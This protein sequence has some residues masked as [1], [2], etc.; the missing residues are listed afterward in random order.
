MPQPYDLI[1]FDWD[2]TIIDSTAV[3]SQ[4]LQA[5]CADLALPIPSDAVANH[6]IGLG[7]KDALDYAV[8]NLPPARIVELAERYRFHFLAGEHRA[9]LF[10]GVPDML[11]ALAADGFLLAV[12]TGKTRRGL[13]RSLEQTQ[14]GH[15][16]AAS[17]CADETFPKPHPAMLEEL[18]GL[19]NIDKSR[20]LM[21]GDTTHDLQMA[22]NAGCASVAV[23][24]GAHPADQLLALKPAACL[25][26]VGELRPWLKTTSI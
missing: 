12:A 14:T 1:V 16:F 17:R 8:P 5:A 13:D 2:G 3:I 9:V 7:L 18:M 26:G 19:F 21:V 25:G 10:A 20:A 23:S 15:F 22:I 11:A 24:S 6:I 4:S